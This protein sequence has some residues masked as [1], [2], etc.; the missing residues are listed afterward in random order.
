MLEGGSLTS[1][2]TGD[3]KVSQVGD[4]SERTAD[5]IAMRH[6]APGSLQPHSML[7]SVLGSGQPLSPQE[8]STFGPQ[9]GAGIHQVRTHEGSKADAVASSFD[10][11]ALSTGSHLVFAHGQRQPDTMSHELGHAF[12]SPGADQVML[13]ATGAGQQAQQQQTQP[14]AGT[15]VTQMNNTTMGG[16][17]TT[18]AGSL[19]EN[20]L[21]GHDARVSFELALNI[22]IL[23]TRVPKLPAGA[24]LN[25][26]LV[27]HGYAGIEDDGG[28]EGGLGLRGQVTGEARALFLSVYGQYFLNAVLE[29]R[30]NS[31]R[32]MFELGL[33]GIYREADRNGVD[34]GWLFGESNMQAVEQDF[35]QGEYVSAMYEDGWS[36]GMATRKERVKEEDAVRRAAGREP[37]E[38]RRTYSGMTVDYTKADGVMH[39][40]TGKGA[41]QVPEYTRWVVQRE[42]FQFR[43]GEL[44]KPGSSLMSWLAKK[45]PLAEA[46]ALIQAMAV[47]MGTLDRVDVSYREMKNEATGEAVQSYRRMVRFKVEPSQLL[48]LTAYVTGWEWAE[49]VWA[50]LEFS[51]PLNKGIFGGNPNIKQDLM[52]A[53]TVGPGLAAAHAGLGALMT[54]YDGKGKRGGMALEG[55]VYLHFNYHE[56][57]VGPETVFSLSVDL[58]ADTKASYDTNDSGRPDNRDRVYGGL[59]VYNNLLHGEI[60]VPSAGAN[61]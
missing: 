6:T 51:D 18:Q 24:S 15:I 12:S 40:L 38:R 60:K 37:L 53:S 49:G 44:L 5:S 58:V 57:I 2:A 46:R 4:H 21:R 41:G 42:L 10:A 30:G 27:V 47:G 48:R 20:V 8:K 31:A 54:T 11:N 25:L 55:G 19:I 35:D 28:V 56:H 61:P 33:Y 59:L 17:F 50:L 34:L 32:E 1:G 45:M 52:R 29:A 39:R 3:L 13:Q 14:N 16:N 22:P 43:P 9:Y 23:G 26:G 7:D 36:V